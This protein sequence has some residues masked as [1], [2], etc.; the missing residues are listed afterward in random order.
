MEDTD[1][2][3]TAIEVILERFF[4]ENEMPSAQLCLGIAGFI[5][6]F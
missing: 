6:K 3:E 1:V 4:L 2:K 5:F